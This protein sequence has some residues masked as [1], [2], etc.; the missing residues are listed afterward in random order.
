M[1]AARTRICRIMSS[2]LAAVLVLM[3]L[4][5]A[6]MRSAGVED[7]VENKMIL[8]KE[9]T[10]LINAERAKNGAEP[11]YLVPYLC[12]RSNV[13]ARECIFLF[14]HDRPNDGGG[15]E[16]VI[17]TSLVPYAT[18]AENIAAY[19]DTAEKA[20]NQWMGSESHRESML[21]PCYTH[22]GVG[23]CYEPNSE[24]EWYWEIL[25]VEYDG[26]LSG[27]DLPTPVEPQCI[28]DLN[29]DGVIDVFDLIFIREYLAGHIKF[30]NAQ[31]E[32]ADLAVDGN[33]SSLDGKV[34]QG[35]VL[36]KYTTL[37]VE[38]F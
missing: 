28:G 32:A 31:L 9:L 30:N 37:P 34:L 8:A 20:F 38:L 10:M 5:Y 2:L 7:T 21:N 33:V 29:G 18:A 16:T 35:Y 15:F 25:L 4:M 12:D 13:R 23:V 14:S 26:E 6:P 22:L 3:N 11:L 19:C 36:G 27:Q 17:D 24:W 1:T